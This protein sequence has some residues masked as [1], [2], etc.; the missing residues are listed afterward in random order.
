MKRILVIDDNPLNN[1]VYT[2]PLEKK[3]QVDIVMSLI[4]VERKLQINQYDLFVIDIMMPTQKYG[5]DNEIITG[6]YF[7]THNLKEQYPNIPILFWSNLPSDAF[8]DYFR[9]D[10]PR[11]VFFIQKAKENNSHLLEKVNKILK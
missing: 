9:N 1:K 10:K 11:N 7:Y 8:D 2:D 6:F 4:S 3:Y 5:G